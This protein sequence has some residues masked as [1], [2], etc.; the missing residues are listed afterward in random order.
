MRSE[1]KQMSE[2]LGRIRTLVD[3]LG[4]NAKVEGYFAEGKV[5]YSYLTAGGFIGSIDSIEYDSRYSAALRT[6]ESEHRGYLVYHAIETKS[7]FGTTLSLLFVGPDE[8]EWEGQRL[9]GNDIYCY[10]ANVDNP[11]WSE[12]GFVTLEGFGGSGALVRTA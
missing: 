10:V 8:K 2:A 4:L 3:S 11:D 5:Y 9:D 6:F 7:A 12:F 1:D